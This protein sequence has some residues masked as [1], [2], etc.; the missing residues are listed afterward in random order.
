[1][2]GEG[3]FDGQ[4]GEGVDEQLPDALVQA[5]AGDGLADRPAVFDAVALADVGGQFMPRR[6]W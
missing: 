2:D 6:W 3:G 5:G 4:R 1:M